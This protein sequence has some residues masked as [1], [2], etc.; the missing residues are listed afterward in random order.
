MRRRS[1]SC[2]RTA[3][4]SILWRRRSSKIETLDQV[5]AYAAAGIPQP[6][7][8]DVGVVEATDAVVSG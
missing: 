7:P 5:A 3:R 2:A 4:S 8:I 6:H 1:S